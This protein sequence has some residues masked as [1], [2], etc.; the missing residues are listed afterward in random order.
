MTILKILV[1]CRD[2]NISSQLLEEI[3]DFKGE[4]CFCARK[5]S[6]NHGV[7]SKGH[8][9]QLEKE[10]TGQIRDNLYQKVM[11]GIE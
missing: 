11:I 1:V 6:K 10:Y 7:V 2:I 3:A 8:R 4:A 9:S 5:Y